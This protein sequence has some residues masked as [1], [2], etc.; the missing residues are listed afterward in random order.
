VR[1]DELE[2]DAHRLAT[3]ADLHLLLE[4]HSPD[5]FFL[6]EQGFVVVEAR[7]FL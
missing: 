1:L 5:I 3:K 6:D 7:H 2:V 4:K